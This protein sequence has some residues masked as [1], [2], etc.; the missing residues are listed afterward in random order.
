M[1]PISILPYLTVVAMMVLTP[2]PNIVVILNTVATRGLRSGFGNLFGVAAGFYFHAFCS[3]IGLTLILKQSPTLYTGV[4]AL[5]AAYLVYLGIT[6]LHLA[7]KTWRSKSTPSSAATPPPPAG[8]GALLQ[9][10]MTNVLNPKVGLFYLAIFPQF[11]G[12]DESLYIKSLT[13][14]TIHAGF[15]FAWYSILIMGFER[16]RTR[17]GNKSLVLGARLGVGM[18]LIGLG[19]KVLMT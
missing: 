18:V 14:V 5:G 15:A 13:L 11:I 3:V 10:F 7:W 6:S 9:G 16:Y 19:A 1:D 8:K 4:K 2:G 12:T 17:L